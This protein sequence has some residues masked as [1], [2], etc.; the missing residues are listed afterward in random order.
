MDQN[1]NVKVLI[2]SG[3]ILILV[4]LILAWV[5]VSGLGETVVSGQQITNEVNEDVES[6]TVSRVIDG[7]TIELTDKRRVRYV[8]VNAPEKNRCFATE[9]TAKNAGLVLGKT[10]R[11]EKD[12]SN[13][14]KYG[15][16]LRFVYVSDSSG[17]EIFVNDFLVRQGFAKVLSVPPDL[18]LE[19]KFNAAAQD[20]QFNQ[21]GLWD[22]CN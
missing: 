6:A 11:L 14:D 18:K 2:I 7:D 22:A 13:R 4:A 20:A 15:R 10:V 3:I 5:A 12:T 16:L 17:R 1:R 8:G 19:S 21:R 9:A